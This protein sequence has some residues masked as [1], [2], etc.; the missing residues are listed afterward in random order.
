[1]DDD[2]QP[3]PDTPNTDTPSTGTPNADILATKYSAKAKDRQEEAKTF[4]APYKYDKVALSLDTGIT[5]TTSADGVTMANTVI[6]HKQGDK[7][8][9][10]VLLCPKFSNLAASCTVF[11]SLKAMNK[12]LTLVYIQ[13]HTGSD[14]KRSKM[15]DTECVTL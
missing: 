3:L 11:N 7:L 5:K 15:V 10:T 8:T 6:T 2:I 13:V 14:R 1:M 4:S 9:S 12:V